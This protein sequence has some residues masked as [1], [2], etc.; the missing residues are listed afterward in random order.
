MAYRWPVIDSHSR[1]QRVHSFTTNAPSCTDS[2]SQGLLGQERQTNSGETPRARIN[3]G[4][5]SV[6]IG[7]VGR[8]NPDSLGPYFV[9]Y[10]IPSLQG[11][12]S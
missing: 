7:L 11:T 9:P 1:D 12:D 2:Y 5:G 8:W 3:A 10:Q 6:G 4:C